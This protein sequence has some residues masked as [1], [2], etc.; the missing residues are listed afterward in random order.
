MVTY[1]GAD[2][3]SDK[4]GAGIHSRK[5]GEILKAEMEKI[6]LSCEL[7]VGKGVVEDQMKFF[8][9]NLK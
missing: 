5:F 2:E 6:G 7:S 4:P 3:P 9:K 8:V 1:T